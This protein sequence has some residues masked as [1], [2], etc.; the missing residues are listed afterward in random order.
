MSLFTN[1]E[2]KE[3]YASHTT[4]ISQITALTKE[5]SD[6]LAVQAELREENAAIVALNNDLTKQIE[7][8]KA[9][10]MT[11][12]EM[13]SRQA[14]DILGQCGAPQVSLAPLSSESTNS[15]TPTSR[16]ERIEALKKQ[17][18]RK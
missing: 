18:S 1:E 15:D 13:A 16:Q 10:K 11:L 5:K 14:L 17:Y 2:I 12:A 4:L 3:M 7:A 9:D 6:L 8:L